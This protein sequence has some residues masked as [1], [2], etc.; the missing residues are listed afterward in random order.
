MPIELLAPAGHI[1][2]FYAAL[3]SGADAVYLGL[4]ELSARALAANFTLQ[5]LAL[6]IPY[7]HKHQQKVHVAL[8]SL[9]TATEIGGTLN[10]LQ[11]L[12]D[13]KVDAL[14]VQDPAIFYL[15]RHYFPNLRLH[16]STLMTIHNHAGVA[17]LEKLGAKRVVLSRELSLEEIKQIANRSRIELEVFVHGA[18]CYSYS[19]LCL[20]SSFRGGQSG[21][22]GRCVQPCRLRF[23]QGR[24]EGFF[25]SCNDLCALPLLPQLKRMRLAAFKIEGRMKS[26]DYIGQV[27]KAYR[28]V[29]DAPQD[30]EHEA[31]TQAQEW[32]ARAPA[33]R[34][35]AGFLKKG[36]SDEVLTPHRSGSS[37]LWVGTVKAV[38]NS[39]LTVSLRHD[40]Q[41]GDRLRP[42][43]L[44]GKEKSAFTITQL[45]S[46]SGSPLSA[47]QAGSTVVIPAK[48]RFQ[49]RERLFRAG[50][51]LRSKGKGWLE[52]RKEIR[53]ALPFR[54]KYHDP[55]K[56][57]D[58]WPTPAV[59]LPGTETLIVKIGRTHEMVPAFQSPAN[60]VVLTATRSNLEKLARKKL[61]PAQK[62]RLV[63]SIPSLVSEKELDYYRPAIDWYRNK[64]FLTW[65]VNNWGHFDFFSDKSGLRLIAGS[66]FNLRNPAALAAV[67]EARCQWSVL[68]LEIT[69]EELRSIG[70]ESTAT[71]PIVTVYAWPPLFT[72][73]LI[74]K[75]LEGKA[76]VTPRKEN[77]FYR[78]SSEYSLIY[79]DR[80]INWM[81][82]IPALRSYG[83]RYFMLDMSDGPHD[84]PPNFEQLL[85][86]FK[87]LRADQPYDLFNY[88]R[89]PIAKR[90]SE[91]E[92]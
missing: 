85:S 92:K 87:R 54:K 1:E 48:G 62:N 63:W 77:Y 91:R 5:E 26:A 42:E 78:K 20:A 74:P 66:R 55:D 57:F 10:I 58:E 17:Q 71:L 15:A 56:I 24:K 70:R 88:D 18:L 72:S 27:V 29:L 9:V 31:V 43:S 21:L 7:A 19:G 46:S 14:I 41:P 32:L 23:R 35:T 81:E 52:I 34:L 40:I 80:P 22:Q 33:R 39:E 82:K 6:L 68:S 25:L 73:R 64:G 4:K 38:N 12:S 2:S 90:K 79:A 51:K 37:G 59:K 30:R 67:A 86:G 83:F 65:E 11:A 60:W 8:N 3:E 50:T 76:F 53:S 28:S 16:A 89:Q 61:I 84:Q 45:F 13:L 75:L 69:Q 44:E 47:G 49:P 36:N